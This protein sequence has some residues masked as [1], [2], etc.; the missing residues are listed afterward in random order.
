MPYRR[1]ASRKKASTARKFSAAVR[2][3]SNKRATRVAASRALTRKIQS[4]VQ[5]G[6]ESKLVTGEVAA[7]SVTT[8]GYIK[9]FF[10]VAQGAGEEQRIGDTLDPT[11]LALDFQLGQPGGSDK[12]NDM[13]VMVVQCKVPASEVTTSDF[14]T[15]SGFVTDAMRRKFR[16]LYDR[17]FTLNAV[18]GISTE[19]EWR[20]Q[21]R[22]V[23]FYGKRL[24]KMR[25]QDT[26]TTAVQPDLSGA[27]KMYVVSNS[28]LTPNPNI[29]YRFKEYSKED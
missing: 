8:A 26:T 13:R 14:P 15:T 5:R 4:V 10:K 16:V 22:S 18:F 1:Y 21:W 3:R 25:W 2:L 11:K 9:E 6:K 7:T 17:V 12:W 20:S 29:A 27:V 19:Q 24:H 28:S 23:S